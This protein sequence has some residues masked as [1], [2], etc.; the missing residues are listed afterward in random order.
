MSHDDKPPVIPATAMWG[1]SLQRMVDQTVGDMKMLEALEIE[2][3]EGLEVEL[4]EGWKPEGE[5]H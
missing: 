2:L 5:A 4:L 3:L 1:D